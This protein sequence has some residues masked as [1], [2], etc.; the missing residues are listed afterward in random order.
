[1]RGDRLL[2]ALDTLIYFWDDCRG[3]S[4]AY[5]VSLPKSARAFSYDALRK[6][7]VRRR[8]S[9][10]T[11]TLNLTSHRTIRRLLRTTK[12]RSTLRNM[13]LNAL[14]MLEWRN[15]SRRPFTYS[16]HLHATLL[17]LIRFLQD[18]ESERLTIKDFQ[19]EA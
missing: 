3:P 11:N 2:L 13:T 4:G 17:P 16:E 18:I 8:Y 7:F 1:M 12:P 10:I 19:E 6:V 9:D 15:N 14:A 5:S